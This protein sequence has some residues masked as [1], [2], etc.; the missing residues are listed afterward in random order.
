MLARVFPAMHT[1][2]VL[3]DAEY[4]HILCG[5]RPETYADSQQAACVLKAAVAVQVFVQQLH[6]LTAVLEPMDFA[7]HA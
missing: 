7:L 2:Y 3:K 1:V 6:Q 5:A 4:L